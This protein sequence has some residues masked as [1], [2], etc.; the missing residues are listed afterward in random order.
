MMRTLG[1][2][3]ALFLSSVEA[4]SAATAP[5][6]STN[7]ATAVTSTS[8]TL[9]GAV[10]PNGFSTNWHFEF[11]TSTSYG[12]QTASEN[13]GSGT[14]AE[15]VAV[16]I[17]GLQA[18]H[19]YH[20]RIV[21]A[22]SGGSS[23]GADQ[24][25]ST[26]NGPAVTTRT[27]SSVGSTT[28]TLN[29]SVNPNGQATS[30]FFEYGTS[31]SYGSKTTV[32][33]AG[34]GAQATNVSEAITGLTAGAT[35][36]FRLDATSAAAGTV[37]GNDQTFATTGPPAVQTGAPSNVTP[38]S[39]TL[40][41]SVDPKG[42]S[43]NWHF[44]YG[45]TTSY[46]S[47]TPSQPEGSGNGPGSVAATLSSLVPGT[48]YH[49]RLVA[50]SQPGT[51]V[52]TDMT[53]ATPPSV[54]LGEAAHQVVFGNYV[55]LSGT[56]FGGQAGV[57]V[58]VLGEAFN[59]TSFTPLGTV[60]TGANGSWTYLVKPAI[61]TSYEAGASG[62]TSST[63]TVGVRPAVSLALITKARFLTAVSPAG[64]FRN[65]TVQLQRLSGSL[66][67]TVQRLRLD[68]GAIFA[69]SGLPHG[70]S[71]LRVALSVNQAGPGYLAGFS[72]TITYRRS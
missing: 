55:R 54:T 39:A 16:P 64:K 48:T 59:A 36:H 53:L 67:V 70:L 13:A 25:F 34:S 8:A 11:G 3:A 21:A 28:A 50:A 20:Y 66:W 52:G 43:T 69:A 22:G 1:L 44:D 63:T 45:T 29:G 10:N 33:S 23:Q 14:T 15:N 61:A 24:T 49:Y 4:G 5:T 40:T 26:G 7:P 38:T 18:N 32:R 30:Y 27:A 62:G 19:T 31:T 47:Q 12:S 65:K 37:L 2:A 56:V 41:G 58:T 57:T 42:Q 35:Y 72:R 68:P 46:G 60:S 6:V 71:L 9:N 51:S 17:V